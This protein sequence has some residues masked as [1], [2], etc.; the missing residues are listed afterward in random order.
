MKELL[1]LAPAVLE[2]AAVWLTLRMALPPAAGRR[3]ARWGGAALCVAALA[4]EGETEV[5]ETG[6]IA[7][8]YEDIARDLRNLGAYAAWAGE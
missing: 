8:G 2:C 4:A 5:S 1:R 6:H 3:W 7:R